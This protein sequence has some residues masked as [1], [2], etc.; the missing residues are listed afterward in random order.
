[1]GRCRFVMIL[2]LCFAISACVL[3][4]ASQVDTTDTNSKNLKSFS[5]DEY[6]ELQ[7]AV[8]HRL[9]VDA[10][11]KIAERNPVWDDKAFEFLNKMTLKLSGKSRRITFRVLAASGEELIHLGCSDPLILNYYVLALSKINKPKE[12]K[13][14]VQ[15]SLN[16]LKKVDILQIS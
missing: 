5:N 2:F 4:S 10:Y 8:N 3:D 1:L 9:I 11:K 7:Y 13:S 6:I 14:V 12:A 15:K 16:G